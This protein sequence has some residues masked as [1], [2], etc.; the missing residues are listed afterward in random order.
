[1]RAI[2]KR[3]VLSIAGGMLFQVVILL[4]GM[5]LQSPVPILIF[6]LPGWTFG[7]AGRDSDRSWSGAI[8]GLIVMLGVNNLFY[9]PAVYFLLWRRK[10][11]KEIRD[12]DLDSF[13]KKPND[14]SIGK[15]EI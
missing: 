6:L 15:V 14:E 7:F 9:S 5:I 13:I 8:I 11:L 4:L 10:V 2:L 1:M 3:I 12:N